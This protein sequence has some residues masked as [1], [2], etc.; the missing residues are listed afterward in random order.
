MGWFSNNHM[1]VEGRTVLMTGASEGTGLCAA[2]I[3]ASKGAN[4]VI[5]SR[6]QDKL[7]SA[8]DL[9]EKTAKS[10]EQRFHAISADVSK[11]KYADSVVEEATQWND[12]Q[13]PEIVWCLA[14]LSTPK[15]WIEDG[16]IEAARHNMDVNYFG[17]AE[18]SQSI[19][20]VWLLPR[21]HDR[22]DGL[23]PKHIIFTGSVLST[24]S[25]VGHG[26]YAPSKFAIRALADA[27]VM[28]VLLYPAVPIKVHLVLP[29]SI[30]TVGLE[31]ENASK[32]EITTKLE[33]PGKPQTP[34][35]VAK[36]AIEGL[37]RGN[38][39]VTTNLMGALMRWG[40]MSN[41][42]RNNWFIDTAMSWIVS[43][44]MLFVMWDMNNQII[45]WG[46]KNHNGRK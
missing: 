39:F 21:K 27:L 7:D 28:E 2:R 29:D 20:R 17:S 46:K 42:P 5:V 8:L 38:Y 23:L 13:P 10:P 34:E 35:L 30:A 11:A 37:E 44:V 14:G 25:M 1:P 19:M 9:I 24:L 36:L 45:T 40:A 33:G 6:N 31:H 32:S 12:G 43:V 15:L 16:A 22:N 18:M 41:S 3:L 4:I 26:T